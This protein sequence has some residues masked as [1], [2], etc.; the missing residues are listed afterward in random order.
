MSVNKV[1]LAGR[2][3]TDTEIINANGNKIAK[4]S[5]ATTEKYKNKAGEQVNNTEWH[6]I[7][8]FG[9]LADV[10]ERY[11]KKGDLLYLE[12]KI[13]TS[14]YEKDG[15]KRYATDIICNNL[16]MLGSK[17]DNQSKPKQQAQQEPEDLNNGD[18]LPF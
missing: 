1:I 6:R 9:K 10:A 4:F 12:G 5:L 7:V 13:K 8:I 2:T 18:N 17:S 11:I 15:I 16:T 14:S 3:G